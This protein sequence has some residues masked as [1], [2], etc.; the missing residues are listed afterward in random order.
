MLAVAVH[1]KNVVIDLSGWSPRLF[2]PNLVEHINGALADKVMFGTDYPW[3]RPQRW[4]N[5]F[6]KLP[7]RE[8]VR[9][10]VL[11]ANAERLLG[12]R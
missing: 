11:R 8:E 3:L 7:I 5:A 9:E 2:S 12:L 6:A 10:K 1:K 4:L